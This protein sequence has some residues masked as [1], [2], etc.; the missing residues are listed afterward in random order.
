MAP[1]ATPKSPAKAKLSPAKLTPHASSPSALPSSTPTKPDKA[2]TKPTRAALDATSPNT[3]KLV[4]KLDALS[5]TTPHASEN[6]HAS[7]PTK[8]V[9]H[10]SPKKE[11]R[12]PNGVD[13]PQITLRPPPEEE[14]FV[15][16]SGGALSEQ[17]KKSLRSINAL[18]GLT[19]EEIEKINKPNVKRLATVTQLCIHLPPVFGA[20]LETLLIIISIC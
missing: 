10:P 14:E 16:P 8:R 11:N 4:S 18:R 13:K 17:A 3:Q 15:G 2:I 12:A 19:V 20:D 6:G 1:S 9:Y 7:S 5:L